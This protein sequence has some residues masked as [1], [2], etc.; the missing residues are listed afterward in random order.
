MKKINLILFGIILLFILTFFT[1]WWHRENKILK[2]AILQQE[3]MLKQKD[4]QIQRLWNQLQV[5]Q[6]DQISLEEKIKKLKEK[7]KQIIKPQ[8]TEEIIKAFKELGYDAM[9]K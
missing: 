5:L 4:I 2:Q 7:Q 1:L 3:Q 8:T 6:K 9:V